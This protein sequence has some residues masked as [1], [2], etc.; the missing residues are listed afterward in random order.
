MPCHGNLLP[1]AHHGP[2]LLGQRSF[3][4][5]APREVQ[6]LWAVA[7][8]GEAKSMPVGRHGSSGFR[9]KRLQGTRSTARG[10]PPVTQGDRGG[11]VIVDRA[12]PSRPTGRCDIGCTC[13]QCRTLLARGVIQSGGLKRQPGLVRRD[14]GTEEPVPVV[15]SV[16][17]WGSRCH[18]L[19]RGAEARIPLPKRRLF[20]PN[21]LRQHRVWLGRHGGRY[22]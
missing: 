2:C 14:C 4:T 8:P 5:A 1:F 11:A 16:C 20:Q 9:I 15:E 13:N 22:V 7:I 6:A 3:A 17:F 12:W 19:R 18:L 21:E 10:T